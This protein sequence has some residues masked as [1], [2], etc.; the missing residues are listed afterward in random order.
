MRR[1]FTL[2]E[3]LITL[4]IIGI[5]ASI[6]IPALI[7]KYQE[8]Q[9]K[10]VVTKTYSA[11]SQATI[12]IKNENGGSL[13]SAFGT[14]P[15]GASPSTQSDNMAQKYQEKLQVTKFCSY[16]DRA[17]CF[18]DIN[19]GNW[20]DKNRIAINRSN[21]SNGA[22]A[23]LILNDGTYVNFDLNSETCTYDGVT[24]FLVP[25]CGFIFIDGNGKN[26]PNSIGNDIFPFYVTK[27]SIVPLD[28]NNV[29][30][31]NLLGC[32]YP[33]GWGC[34]SYLLKGQAWQ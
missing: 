30:P 26:S 13:V 14:T 32:F 31:V 19:T 9:I 21:D 15:S 29:S 4:G 8:L 6:T 33:R 16:T 1:G 23:I 5:I 12:M 18:G 27:D 28:D 2:A 20:W 25:S 24:N 7:Q 3:V 10:D 34:T 11:L 22:G 17:G